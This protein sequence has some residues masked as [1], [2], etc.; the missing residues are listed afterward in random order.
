MMLSYLRNKSNNEE[1]GKS[2]SGQS[3]K[4]SL[5]AG[6]GIK[7]DVKREFFLFFFALGLNRLIIHSFSW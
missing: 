1:V 7:V 3:L 2:P 5:N 6:V 4:G